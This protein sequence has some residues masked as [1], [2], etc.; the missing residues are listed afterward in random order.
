MI[1]RQGGSQSHGLLEAE[2]DFGLSY[3]VQGSCDARRSSGP[4]MVSPFWIPLAG[5]YNVGF[6]PFRRNACFKK[7]AGAA[8]S[9]EVEKDK[10]I[11]HGARV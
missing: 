6:F 5:F 4:V 11:G 8:R 1:S 3:H 10:M 2:E 9:I 7:A